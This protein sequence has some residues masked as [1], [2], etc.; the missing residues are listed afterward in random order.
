MSSSGS[1]PPAIACT[2]SAT[3]RPDRLREIAEAFV[4]VSDTA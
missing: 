2:L 4:P 3:E 1:T